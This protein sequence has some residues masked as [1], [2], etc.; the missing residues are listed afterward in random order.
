MARI[1]PAKAVPEFLAAYGVQDFAKDCAPDKL[2][3]KVWDLYGTKPEDEENAP[4]TGS[5]IAA[6]VICDECSK[7]VSL[8]RAA[9]AQ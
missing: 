3:I 8:D 6:V 9:L 4:G 7:H 5:F 2:T 1:L